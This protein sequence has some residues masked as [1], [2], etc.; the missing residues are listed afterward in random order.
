MNNSNRRHQ[1]F[2][3]RRIHIQYK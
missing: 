3:K 2:Q 1:T